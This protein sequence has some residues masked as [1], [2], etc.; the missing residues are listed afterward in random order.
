MTE[1][2]FADLTS[3]ADQQRTDK[4]SVDGDRH[5]YT[6]LYAA[7]FE[8]FRLQEFCL[9]ELGLLR[10]PTREEETDP[11]SR[12]VT[13][14]PSVEMWLQY[15]PKA[16]CYGF[17]LADFAALEKPRFK[18]IRGDLSADSDIER[19]ARSVPTPRI[20]IDDAS[21]ASFHQQRAFLRLFPIL[22]PGGFYVI[23]DLHYSPPFEPSLPPCRP[24]RKVVEEFLETGV[25]R[26]DFA[27]EEESARLG[28]QI[29]HSFLHCSERGSPAWGPKLVMFQKKRAVISQPVAA[30]RR[31]EELP[32][33]DQGWLTTRLFSFRGGGQLHCAALRFDPDGRISGYRHPNEALWRFAGGRLTICRVDGVPSCVASP[34]R[35]DDGTVSFVGKFL[36][37]AD[38]V[39]R[40]DENLSD[41]GPP[42]VFSF[43]LFDTLVARRCYDPI[44]IFHAVER[45]SGVV[46]F[47]RRR[48]DDESALWQAGDYTLDDIYAQLRSRTGWPEATLGRLRMLELAEE[49]DNLFPIQEMTPRV[50]SGDLI[51][52][53]MYL[54]LKFLRRVVE[55]KCGLQGCV[56]HLSSHGK[57]RG[58][59]WGKLRATH[60][61]MRHYGDNHHS[62]VEGARRA[63]LVAEHVTLSRW[64]R[65]E[66]ILVDTGLREFAGIVR[67]AR[68]TSFAATPLIREAQ[69]AQL[70]LNIP[71]LILAGLCVLKRA[72]ER[73]IDTLLLCSRDC[74]LWLSLMQWMSVR[75]STAA[76]VRYF[77][78]SRVLQL[79]GSTEYHGY[80]SR[81][82]GRRSMLVDVSGTGRSPAH[83]LGDVGDQ[84][85]ASIFLLV[86]GDGVAQAIGELA[87]ARNDVELDILTRQPYDKRIA[88][89]CLNMSLAGRATQVEFTGQ[90]FEV[91]Q[92]PNEFG[93]VAQGVIAAM[94]TVFLDL[95][96]LLE[97]SDIRR[98]PEHI[99][100]DTLRSAAESLI[101]SVGDYGRAIGP[102]AHDIHREEGVIA[103]MALAERERNRVAADTNVTAA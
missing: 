86:A 26:L 20:I 38:V 2:R 8:S 34:V 43:D 102:I 16:T 87:P 32:A 97:E 60:R 100:V 96:R 27:S 44:G 47:A 50:R 54:P 66:Q 98:L 69:L 13:R 85:N 56:I 30:A 3:L 84:A 89:E 40:F 33:I 5:L 37:A 76:I 93:K 65:G 71:L 24:M 51:I 53:D 7:T 55:E 82:R 70:N 75:S 19:L 99:P 92:L 52:S 81:M 6:E 94:R 79:S 9:L 29:A 22:E 21:H 57:H 59:I 80:Y 28:E 49:W 101:G 35:N 14:I 31:P 74:N 77:I 1:P 83:F 63:K 62:D 18:F 68:L 10:S 11:A 61:I 78:T 12:R 39:H 41:D 72:Q 73:E 88:I 45:K 48:Q 17:D 23:E 103:R 4:G 58:E 90:G 25:L 15:F 67:E 36:F 46:G 91:Q 64:S 42:M 95:T